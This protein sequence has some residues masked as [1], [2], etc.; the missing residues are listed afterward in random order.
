[1]NKLL[2][3]LAF[4]AF[5]GCRD[6]TPGLQSIGSIQS[7]DP[8]LE[9]I[10][11]STAPVEIIAEGFNWTEGP[12]WAESEKMLLFSDIPPNKIFKWTEAKGAELYLTPSGYT[13]TVPRTGE[14]GSNGLL[15]NR[16]GKLVLCQHGD[17][18]MA[19]MDAPLNAPEA[20]FVSLADNYG[21]K[22]F[23]SPNDAVFRSNGDLFFTDPAYGLEKAMDDPAKEIPFQGVYKVNSQGEVRL[24]TNA[25]TRPNGIA[26]INNEKTLIVANSDPQ[27]PV[28]Y[29]FDI[30]AGD[31]LHNETLLFDATE[32][33]KKE[34]GMPDGLKVDGQGNIFATGPGGVWIFNASGKLAGKISVPQ[35]CSNV[36][37]ADGD[38]TLYI[39]ANMYVL[40]VKMRK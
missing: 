35:P 36:A 25:I 10:I 39:T 34:Q 21:G 26:F 20:A 13:G 1:M 15:L 27:K 6:K 11:D 22:R 30:D 14:P 17:R 9:N 32:A 33:S 8:S 37:L 40:R 2:F 16:E 23:N 31:S 12:L 24:L 3:F 38:K 4:A 5:A 18:R 7:L 28:W 19:I 29:M